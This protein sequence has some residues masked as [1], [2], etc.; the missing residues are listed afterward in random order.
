MSYVIAAPELMTS[1]ATDLATIGSNLTVAHMAAAR[2]DSRDAAR[3]TRKID[4][5][6]NPWDLKPVSLVALVGV[7]E[8][9]GAPT[10]LRS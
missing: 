6:M 4:V 7:L 10:V 9:V 1:A 3:S 2:P 8:G 5:G